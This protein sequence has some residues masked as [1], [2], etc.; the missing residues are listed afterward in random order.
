MYGHTVKLI[1]ARERLHRPISEGAKQRFQEEFGG[2]T[3]YKAASAWRARNGPLGGPAMVDAVHRLQCHNVYALK[4]GG[5]NN[6]PRVPESL[7]RVPFSAH[8]VFNFGGIHGTSYA[9]IGK[10]L[11]DS[12]CPNGATVPHMVYPHQRRNSSSPFEDLRRRFG[13]KETDHLLCRHGGRDTFDI[14][15][16][17][18]SIPSLL[19]EFPT[20]HLL[21][22]NTNRQL[23]RR[24][25]K[26]P[27]PGTGE[28]ASHSDFLQDHPRLHFLDA[29]V[30]DKGRLEYFEACDGML[31]ARGEGETFGLSVAEMSVHNRPVI[32][33]TSGAQEHIRIL[34][35]RSFVYSDPSSLR[36]RIQEVLSIPRPELLAKDW[37]AYRMFMPQ[38]VMQAFDNIFIQPALVYWALLEQKGISNPWNVSMDELPPRYNYFVRCHAN[39]GKVLP[40][41]DTMMRWLPRLCPPASI[42]R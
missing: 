4:R 25:P 1:V 5:P 33:S 20:L 29:R 37:N 6:E 35:N 18:D 36:K 39:N 13:V 15:F 23:R 24:S 27:A 22:M 28:N 3:A 16:V 14:D 38:P 9:A 30:D 26:R 8:A 40:T 41:S 7:I 11:A 19:D 12:E 17:R 2:F 34:G 32:T 10:Q 21:L 42:P 31:H